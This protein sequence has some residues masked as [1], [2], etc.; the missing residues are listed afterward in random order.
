MDALFAHFGDHA[1]VARQFNI[2]R[3][4][5]WQWH[6]RGYVSSVVALVADELRIPGA[7][8]SDLRPDIRDWDFV[9]DNELERAR[10]GNPDAYADQ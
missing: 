2:S 9:R 7:S 4:K 6:E 3:Q 10:S 5:V 1:A 8:K